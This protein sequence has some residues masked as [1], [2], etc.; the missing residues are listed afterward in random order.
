MLII[1]ADNPFWS[2]EFLDTKVCFG[3]GT[4]FRETQP[5]KPGSDF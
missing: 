3:A 2:A 5:Q 1:I 4:V